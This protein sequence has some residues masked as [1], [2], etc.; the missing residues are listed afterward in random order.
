M[1]SASSTDSSI[2]S[3][4]LTSRLMTE[5]KLRSEWA[6]RTRVDG[7]LNSTSTGLNT[8]AKGIREQAIKLAESINSMETRLKDLLEQ[9]AKSEVEF[10]KAENKMRRDHQN[11]ERQADYYIQLKEQ[12]LNDRLAK[13]EEDKRDLIAQY[14]KMFSK[15]GD[16]KVAAKKKFEQLLAAR[17]EEYLLK[18]YQGNC[19]Q[20]QGLIERIAQSRDDL[21]KVKSWLAS[22]GTTGDKASF[23]QA[24]SAKHAQVEA[25][26]REL[27]S[28]IAA[29]L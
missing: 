28:S 20:G 26:T 16:Q 22:V 11:W 4:G 7:L 2:S 10:Q 6:E 14:T 27:G 5:G 19:D 18:C 8:F 12:E 25:L 9:T 17:Q 3:P 29:S 23:S 13:M 24:L 21:A 15:F 1:S